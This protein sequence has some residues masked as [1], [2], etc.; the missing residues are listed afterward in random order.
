MWIIIKFNKKKLSSLKDDFKKKLGNNCVFYQPKTKIQRYNKNKLRELEFPLLGNYIFCYHENFN[1]YNILSNLKFSKGLDYILN[2]SKQSQNEIVSFISRCKSLTDNSGF[3]S[4]SL[5]DLKINTNYRFNT[6][7][8]V[9][10][11]FKIIDL[12]K[13]KINILLGN[14][15]TTLNKK[16][17]LFSQI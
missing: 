13:N 8:F 14:V 17:F 4:K 1:N 12:Q 11:I 7:P 15:K 6:G 2:G 3:I 9:E 10:K 5:F 16:D